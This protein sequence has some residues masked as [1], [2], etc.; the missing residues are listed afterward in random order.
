MISGQPAQRWPVTEQQDENDPEPLCLGIIILSLRLL[1]FAFFFFFK[2]TTADTYS[3]PS[4]FRRAGG[5]SHTPHIVLQGPCFL[6]VK[7]A[8]FPVTISSPQSLPFSEPSSTSFSQARPCCLHSMSTVQLRTWC[9]HP[10][11]RF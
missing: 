1:G 3:H 8:H 2:C 4:S 7:V 11:G 5:S 9:M 6:S 10:W